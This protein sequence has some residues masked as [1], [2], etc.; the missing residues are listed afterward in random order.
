MTPFCNFLQMPSYFG[1]APNR[2]LLGF[3]E[4]VFTV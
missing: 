2:E 1:V 3:W 4:H